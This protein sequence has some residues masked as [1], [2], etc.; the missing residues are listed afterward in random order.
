MQGKFA[1]DDLYLCKL[2]INT[3]ISGGKIA[4]RVAFKMPILLLDVILIE[5]CGV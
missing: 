2:V 1:I 3:V 4:C 5:V